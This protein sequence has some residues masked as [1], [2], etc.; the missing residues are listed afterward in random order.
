[1]V[2]SIIRSHSASLCYA[3]GF[4]KNGKHFTV[5]AGFCRHGNPRKHTW[6][7][8]KVYYIIMFRKK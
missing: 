6:L 1:M 7:N 2:I 4:V 3:H 8:I 5:K